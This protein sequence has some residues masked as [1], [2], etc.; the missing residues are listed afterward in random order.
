MQESG[1]A[2]RDGAPKRRV[3]DSIRL[4]GE[5]NANEIQVGGF[6]HQ[7]VPGGSGIGRNWS[8]LPRCNNL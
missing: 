7:F 8:G 1:F 3:R 6:H 5:N 2:N 4:R